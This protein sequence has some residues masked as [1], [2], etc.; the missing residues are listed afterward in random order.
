MKLTITT[1]LVIGFVCATGSVRADDA[2]A[3]WNSKCASCHAKDGT[4]HTMMG[5]K[6][7]VKDLT[8]AKVQADL[9]D[10]DAAKAIN[11]GV[12][13]NGATKMKAFK[14]ILKDDEI[15]ALVAHIRTF[16]K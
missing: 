15:T 14:G 5:K 10:A 1:L 3:L 16:K 2:T 12:K 4:G 13:V 7:K 9:T 11:E 6:D 8:D